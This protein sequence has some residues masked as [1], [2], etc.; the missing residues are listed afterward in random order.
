VKIEED[1]DEN[2]DMV[3]EEGYL[4]KGNTAHSRSDRAKA[5]GGE[6]PQ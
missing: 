5:R 6:I 2:E 1:D 3:D 4:A